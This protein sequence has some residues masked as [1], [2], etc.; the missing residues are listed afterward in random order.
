MVFLSASQAKLSSGVVLPRFV[1][2]YVLPEG[3]HGAVT[4]LMGYGP[5]ARAPQVGVGDEAGPQRVGRVGERVD[6][7]PLDSALY[8]VVDG[9]GA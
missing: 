3:R 8:Q 1:D 2:P 9:L 6:A 7:G 5:V 4:G